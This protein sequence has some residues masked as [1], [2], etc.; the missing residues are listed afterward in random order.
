MENY[1]E[2]NFT[3]GPDFALMAKDAQDKAGTHIF[4]DNE[5]P[6]L[7]SLWLITES[8]NALFIMRYVAKPEEIEWLMREHM[9]DITPLHASY[10]VFKP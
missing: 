9:S 8:H 7:W 1:F 4:L 5:N 3:I 2:I 10:E 6:V